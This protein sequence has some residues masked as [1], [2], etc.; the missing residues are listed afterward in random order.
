MS[1][2]MP[3]IPPLR[4]DPVITIDDVSAGWMTVTLAGEWGET[5]IRASY[6]AGDC[7]EGLLVAAREMKR[8]GRWARVRLGEE[9]SEVRLLLTREDGDSVRVELRRFDQMLGSAPDDRGDLVVSGFWSATVFWMSV[10]HAAARLAQTMGAAAYEAAW[11]Y[12][13]PMEKLR[14][15]VE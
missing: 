10:A 12:R 7:M 8:G 14:A 5:S 4:T 6:V 2:T 15:L 9:P 13:F 1:S 3:F 11:R